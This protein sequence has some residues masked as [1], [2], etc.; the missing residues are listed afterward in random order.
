LIEYRKLGKNLLKVSEIALG[1]QILGGDPDGEI[2][3]ANSVRLIQ[4]ALMI[5]NKSEVE[6]ESKR[7]PKSN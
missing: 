7:Y 3:D 4:Y 5:M 1:C 6:R 2:T